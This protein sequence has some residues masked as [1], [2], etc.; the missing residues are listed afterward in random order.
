M[1]P[2]EIIIKLFKIFVIV[3]VVHI[4]LSLLLIHPLGMMH[5]VGP[6]NNVNTW[7]ESRTKRY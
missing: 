6:D 2:K 5:K 4:I 1:I 3:R 7:Y